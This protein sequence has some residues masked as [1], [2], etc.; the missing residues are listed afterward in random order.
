MYFNFLGHLASSSPNKKIGGL[1]GDDPASFLGLE[2]GRF[3]VKGGSVIAFR[4][5][6]RSN[7]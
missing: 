1:T 3:A 5:V 4:T 6:L 7:L 2:G